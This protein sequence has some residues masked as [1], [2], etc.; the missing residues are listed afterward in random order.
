MSKNLHKTSIP[1]RPKTDTHKIK[2]TTE[3]EKKRS[4]TTLSSKSTSKVAHSTVVPK[5]HP[6][7]TKKTEETDEVKKKKKEEA[8]KAKRAVKK[9]SETAAT[10]SVA[11]S[12]KRSKPIRSSPGTFTIKFVSRKPLYEPWKEG[13][14]LLTSYMSGRPAAASSSSRN[15]E[16]YFTK[17]IDVYGMGDYYKLFASVYF[18][19]GDKRSGGCQLL[20]DSGKNVLQVHI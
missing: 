2:K 10:P 8:K 3:E 6:P 9:D 1:S 17:V 20:V 19:E 4:S 5:K 13:R 14:G 16:G 12:S 7:T 11:A 18:G 15:N